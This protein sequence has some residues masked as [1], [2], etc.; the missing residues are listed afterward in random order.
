MATI[1]DWLA[2]YVVQTLN[3]LASDP[4]EARVRARLAELRRG[5]GRRPGDMPELWGLLFSDMPE[6]MLS[7]GGEPTRAEWAAYTA[8]TLYALHQQS[9]DVRREN[10]YQEGQGLGRAVG[11]LV[12][13]EDD[14]ERVARRFNAF[15]TADDMQEAAHHL[16]GLVQLLRAEGIP[17]DYVRLALDLY[18]FQFPESAPGVRLRWGQD[19]Y[20]RNKA[21]D[22]RNDEEERNENH[23]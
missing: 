6:A 15:A 19:F 13:S 7:D 18:D 12:K 9:R 23:A 11:R 22:E 10:M 16:R 20:R 8:L 21:D 2:G 5:V 14:R 4:N 17:M 3:K 1:K